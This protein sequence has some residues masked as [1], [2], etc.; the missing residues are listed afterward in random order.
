MKLK[1]KYI[2]LLPACFLSILA[3][4]EDLKLVMLSW[5]SLLVRM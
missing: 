4:C 3:G 2:G 1:F 5:K